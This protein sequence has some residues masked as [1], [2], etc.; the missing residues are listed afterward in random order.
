MVAR[1]VRQPG[2]RGKLTT[3]T[4]FNTEFTTYPVSATVMAADGSATL[5]HKT[6]VTLRDGW[7]GIWDTNVEAPYIFERVLWAEVAN[8]Y[9]ERLGEEAEATLLDG[10]T[11]RVSAPAGCG[12]GD[13]GK[14]HVWPQDYIDHR[15]IILVRD[16]A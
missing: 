2:L 16:A 10:S 5:Y 3:M 7:L 4:T 9:I 1:Q 14:R 8:G 13:P 11:V 6:R 15:N 12:C